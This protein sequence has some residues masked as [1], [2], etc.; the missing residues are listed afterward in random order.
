MKFRLEGLKDIK[1]IVKE[2]SV[3]LRNLTFADN[4]TSFEVDV[5]IGNGSTIIV[6]NQLDVIPTRYLIVSNDGDGTISK[7][8]PWDL[9]YIS[10][11]N[12]GS[13]E[14]DVKIIITK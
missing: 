9:N 3:G 11:K 5:T 2:L 6:R 13:I 12:N 7:G 10:F 1:R 14:A 4:F 8:S